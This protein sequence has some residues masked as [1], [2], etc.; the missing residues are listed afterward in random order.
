MA[1]FTL[2]VHI[3]NLPDRP[4]PGSTDG[5]MRKYD[6]AGNLLWTRQFGSTGGIDGRLR[7][8]ADATGIYVTV[9]HSAVSYPD[10]SQRGGRGRL[11]S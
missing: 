4:A 11:R 5:F 8:A 6:S 2:R 3:G 10:Q 7:V 1:I 9:I